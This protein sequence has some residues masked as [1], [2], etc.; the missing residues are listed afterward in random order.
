MDI[1]SRLDEIFAQS[2]SDVE[3]GFNNYTSYIDY[4]MPSDMMEES[5][6]YLSFVFDYN[7]SKIVLN[8]NVAGVL[9]N[10]YYSG[11][12][13]NEGFFSEDKIFYGVSGKFKNVDNEE[14]EYHYNIYEYEGKYLEYFY[15]KDLIVYGYCTKADI[16]NSSLKILTLAK[17]SSVDRNRIVTNFS[18][19]DVIDYQRKQ[20]DLF[21]TT[22]PVNGRVDELIVDN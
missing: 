9:S 14:N 18:S 21:E 19:K 16:V 3:P 1:K 7:R 13:L 4:Y 2:T 5:S 12:I 22:L 20:V 17:D 11:N 10:K 15:S 6:D 8:V